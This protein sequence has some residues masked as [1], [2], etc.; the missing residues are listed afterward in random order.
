MPGMSTLDIDKKI[1]PVKCDGNTAVLFK[2]DI[3]RITRLTRQGE[4]GGVFGSMKNSVFV[5]DQCAV[6]GTDPQP[7][8]FV[9]PEKET[10]I[11]RQT[12][13]RGKVFKLYSVVPGNPLA[14]GKPDIPVL[15]VV[16]I[17]D[18][19]AGQAVFLRK[20][21]GWKIPGERAGT[22]CQQQQQTQYADSG[23]PFTGGTK[24]P[25]IPNNAAC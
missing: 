5:K 24:T 1:T 17:I 11:I 16:H 20:V 8:V 25:E 12:V 9:L 23:Y 21:D 2:K 7:F 15:I 13:C 4:V 3:Q 22:T 6:E 19:I 10:F 14:G 18:R